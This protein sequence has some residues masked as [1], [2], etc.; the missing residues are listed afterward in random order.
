MRIA[1]C[2]ESDDFIRRL[3][4]QRTRGAHA[5]A[6]RAACRNASMLNVCDV[7]KRKQYRN[8]LELNWWRRMSAI[9]FLRRDI[10]RTCFITTQLLFCFISFNDPFSTW[11]SGFSVLKGTSLPQTLKLFEFPA[12]AAA[13]PRRKP[14]VRQFTAPMTD[15]SNH[16]K[17]LTQVNLTIRYFPLQ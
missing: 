3:L 13:K 1:A 7:R 6:W 2:D 14:A 11:Q 15:S 16:V 12:T 8:Q 17:M 5:D 10:A 9:Q 4:T